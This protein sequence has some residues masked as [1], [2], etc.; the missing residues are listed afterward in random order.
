MPGT[1]TGI[2]PASSS[3]T[4]FVSL[5]DRVLAVDPT[6]GTT[7]REFVPINAGQIDH[8]APALRPI[9]QE[10]GSYVQCAC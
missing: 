3:R 4:L 8:V 10:N 7:Q 2:Q 6:T 1:V 5:A 9:V